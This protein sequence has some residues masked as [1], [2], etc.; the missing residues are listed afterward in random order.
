MLNEK[1][2]KN[3]ILGRFALT[4]VVVGLFQLFGNVIFMNVINPLLGAILKI[5]FLSSAGFTEGLTFIIVFF[6][7]L[8]ALPDL[9][10]NGKGKGSKEYYQLEGALVSGVFNLNEKIEVLRKKDKAK[11]LDTFMKKN[12][13]K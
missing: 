2:L 10:K 9:I 12:L 13:R 7:A 5:D 6:I 4:L 1:K 11:E 3:Y 8:V